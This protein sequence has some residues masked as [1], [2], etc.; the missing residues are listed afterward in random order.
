M[1]LSE[2][3]QVFNFIFSHKVIRAYETRNERRGK[4]EKEVA[5]ILERYAGRLDDLEEFLTTQGITFHVLGAQDYSLAH[6]GRVYVFVR[7]FAAGEPP[8]HLGIEHIW[9]LFKDDRRNESKK[10]TSIWTTY[11]FLHLLYFLYTTDSRAIESISRYRDTW[12]DFDVFKDVIVSSIDELRSARDGVEYP[13]GQIRE[14]LCAS[15]EREINSR[16][17]RFFKVLVQ[18]GALEK[19]ADNG[20][21]LG[22]KDNEREIYQQT[23]W[24]AVDIAENFKRY[25]SLLINTPTVSDVYSLAKVSE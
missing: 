24:F 12:V 14:Q 5:S 6:Q 1:T 7:S 21:S 2:I 25:A 11:L 13:E 8:P 18:I 23:L 17:I 16:V 15:D 9:T 22:R 10:D 19:V 3:G 20:F 4:E